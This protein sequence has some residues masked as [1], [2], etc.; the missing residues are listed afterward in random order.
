MLVASADCNGVL[1][2]GTAAPELHRSPTRQ[3]LLGFQWFLPAPRSSWCSRRHRGAGSASAEEAARILS[4]FSAVSHPR[5]DP[6]AEPELVL[7]GH[8]AARTTA[9][10]SVLPSPATQVG[11]Q[12]RHSFASKQG[13]VAVRT[14]AST[15]AVP[16]GQRSAVQRSGRRQAGAAIL[17]QC[18]CG[19]QIRCNGGFGGVLG[20]S[21]DA[22]KSVSSRTKPA[23][24][25]SR[26]LK[27]A[28]RC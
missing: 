21:I 23:Y 7:A 5:D 22:R 27:N 12:Q 2:M 25:S 8:P 18:P 1:D 24:H 26:R 10:A 4:G 28:D 19:D 17:G 16:D 6:R 15:P 11:Y 13:A 20:M 14:P 3:L 9:A